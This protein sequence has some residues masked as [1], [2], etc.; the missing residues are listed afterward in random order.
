MGHVHCQ[1]SSLEISRKILEDDNEPHSKAPWSRVNP[2]SPQA[3]AL[4]ERPAP[5]E[6][7]FARCILDNR[8]NC[9]RLSL[10]AAG[11]AGSCLML[12][13]AQTQLL[14]AA[15][16]RPLPTLP[17]SAATLGSAPS[18][19]SIRA[20]P[21]SSCTSL[22]RALSHLSRPSHGLSAQQRASN[23]GD[24]EKMEENL[25]GGRKCPRLERSPASGAATKT[26]HSQN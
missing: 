3:P 25:V 13:G 2:R 10:R 15:P 12:A 18:A 6:P 4:G 1:G 17:A 11:R 14:L 24:D 21:P 7:T 19:V 9:C 22:L 20:Q 26:Q 16:A 23:K 8:E 5:P